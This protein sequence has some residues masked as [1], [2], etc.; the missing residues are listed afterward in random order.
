MAITKITLRSQTESDLFDNADTTALESIDVAA[1]IAKFEQVWQEQV[2]RYYADG[3]PVSFKQQ[4]CHAEVYMDDEPSM[5]ANAI[6]EGET[7]QAIQT[8]AESIFED[9]NLWMVER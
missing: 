2:E 1:S 8:L 4:P 9:G 5:D 3:A 6:A 7:E